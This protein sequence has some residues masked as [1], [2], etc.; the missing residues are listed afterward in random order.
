MAHKLIEKLWES[1][2]ITQHQQL[3]SGKLENFLF[4]VL[5]VAVILAA[6]FIAY[7]VLKGL[8]RALVSVKN[9]GPDFLSKVFVSFGA[10]VVAGLIGAIAF[11]FELKLAGG[12]GLAGAVLGAIFSS[13]SA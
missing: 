9:N 10:S 12:V 1:S 7:L 8:W 2:L 4:G 5:G 6:G 3:R 13:R 11:G